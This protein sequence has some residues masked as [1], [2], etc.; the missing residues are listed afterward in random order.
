[1]KQIRQNGFA[2]ILVIVVMALISVV[3]FLL[4]EDANT[5]VFQ[6]DI[7]YLEAVEQNLIASSLAWA[8]QNVKNEN[9]EIFPKNIELD[10][11]AMN[12]R[13][14]ILSVTIGA[15]R[16][17]EVQVEVSASYSRGRRT[18]RHNDKYKIQI[19]P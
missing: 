19:S 12:I 8:K 7:A 14:A 2:L 9:K 5:I 18:L 17:N 10:V 1:M 4:T 15:P 6:S 16:D 13:D 11:S 3:V